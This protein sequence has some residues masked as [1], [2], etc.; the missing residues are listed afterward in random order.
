[1]LL[2]IK[3]AR[4]HAKPSGPSWMNRRFQMA[5]RSNDLLI[6]SPVRKTTSIESKNTPTYCRRK[7]VNLKGSGP[8]NHGCETTLLHFWIA[9]DSRTIFLALISYEHFVASNL[10]KIQLWVSTK[11]HKA[12]ES[13][14]DK[15]FSSVKSRD[16]R[17]DNL[18]C[19][20]DYRRIKFFYES[21]EELQSTFEAAQ[22]EFLVTMSKATL[23]RPKHSR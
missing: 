20:D 23:N 9:F 10:K 17:G 14:F 21:T 13:L 6:Q 12:S 5:S 1:M 22:C 3:L 19:E 11:F 16:N 18:N 2:A 7:F 15:T 4:S 8:K